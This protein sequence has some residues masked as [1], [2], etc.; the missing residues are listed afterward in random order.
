MRVIYKDS[1]E[2]IE[3]DYPRIDISIPVENLD[4]N[5]QFYFIQEET[6]VNPDC[7]LYDIIK[8]SDE[9]T[10]EI[11]PQYSH[12]K[13]CKRIFQLVNKLPDK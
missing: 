6:V 4:T 2:T 3:K 7:S 8:E 12:L 1:V 5:I 11:H 10:N 13:I 9:L